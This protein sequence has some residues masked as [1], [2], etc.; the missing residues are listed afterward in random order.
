[1]TDVHLSFQ[2]PV[3]QYVEVEKR[4]EVPICSHFRSGLNRF[5]APDVLL[6]FKV[7]VTQ[8]VEIEKVV[9]VPHAYPVRHGP[10]QH[11]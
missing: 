11:N 8:Y 9:E 10:Q 4:V 1:M 6:F 5:G 3:T 2:V 7:P